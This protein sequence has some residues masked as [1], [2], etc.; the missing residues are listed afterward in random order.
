MW[1]TCSSLGWIQI[2]FFFSPAGYICDPE[3]VS[4]VSCVISGISVISVSRVIS[5]T[6]TRRIISL[7]I[8]SLLFLVCDPTWGEEGD[9]N[10]NQT[11][12][13]ANQAGYS[14]L[15]NPYTSKVMIFRIFRIFFC[16]RNFSSSP[17]LT[18]LVRAYFPIS[19]QIFVFALPSLPLPLFGWVIT[20][21]WDSGV[22]ATTIYKLLNFL[23]HLCSTAA[24]FL[25]RE[26]R[27]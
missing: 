25:N 3:S 27:Q 14:S 5:E 16:R 18:H 26:K 21:L 2:R 19:P 9:Q 10:R 6:Y 13:R 4:S 17:L 15:L 22:L 11:G 12:G 7:H 1:K 20:K 8:F 23:F 24:W